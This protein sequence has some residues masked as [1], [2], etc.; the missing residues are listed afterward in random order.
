MATQ[1]VAVNL[2]C[3]E[4]GLLF[5]DAKELSNHK[6][7]FCIGCAYADPENLAAVTKRQLE[8]FRAD[9]NSR[10]PAGGTEA[11]YN[12]ELE[13]DLATE[14]FMLER[15]QAS[16]KMENDLKAQRSELQ[17][18]GAHEEQ[19]RKLLGQLEET[20]A[21][22][23]KAVLRAQQY[24]RNL[25]EMDR[26]HIETLQ[27]QKREELEALVAE[28]E[29][30]ERQE[31]EFQRE[32]EEMEHQA[33]EL[34]RARDAEEERLT[35]LV[36]QNE[37]TL[38]EAQFDRQRQ[39]AMEHGSKMEQL[40]MERTKLTEKKHSITF[41]LDQL[42]DKLPTQSSRKPT[43]AVPTRLQMRLRKRIDD[44]PPAS[45]AR[46]SFVSAFK[47]DTAKVSG[48]APE[49]IDIVGIEEGSVMVTF[50]IK[51]GPG[52]STADA[53]AA[54]RS[55]QDGSSPTPIAGAMVQPGGLLV[56]EHKAAH[57]AQ[58]AETVEQMVA[59]LQAFQAQDSAR[60]EALR[61]GGANAPPKA[62]VSEA[63]V[64]AL[65]DLEGLQSP[66]AIVKQVSEKYN[67][68][69]EDTTVARELGEVLLEQVTG[70]KYKKK[71]FLPRVRSNDTSSTP[72]PKETKSVSLP[73]INIHRE[74]AS[75]AP[76]A[77]HSPVVSVTQPGQD[78]AQPQAN[79]QRMPAPAPVS[80]PLGQPP[81]PPQQPPLPDSQQQQ[82]GYMPQ[83]PGFPAQ[84]GGF[85]PQPQGY[86]PSSF[87]IHNPYMFGAQQQNPY[88]PPTYNPYGGALPGAFSPQYA[89]QMQLQQQMVQ[90]QALMQQHEEENQRIQQLQ[91]GDAGP[92]NSNSTKTAEFSG[93]TGPKTDDERHH[94]EMLA[95]HQ[96]DMERMR[97]DMEKLQTEQQLDKLM[98]EAQK[99]RRERNL[100]RQAEEAEA[101]IREAKLRRQLAK[102]YPSSVL[103]TQQQ[104][105][106]DP[107]VYDPVRG[108]TIFMDFVFGLPSK[109]VQS[110]LVYGVYDGNAPKAPAKMLSLADTESA[111]AA[112]SM[113]IFAAKRSFK[114]INGAK[115]LKLVFEPH[116]STT[117]ASNPNV[118]PATKAIGWTG[119]HLFNE[120][121]DGGDLRLN[122]GQFHLPIFRPPTQ[123]TLSPADMRAKPKVAKTGVF[124][125]VVSNH[126][127]NQE[128]KDGHEKF[129]INPPS[130]NNNYYEMYV[131]GSLDAPPDMQQK[132]APPTTAKPD[133]IGL[134]PEVESA[135]PS[136]V[137]DTQGSLIRGGRAAGIVPLNNSN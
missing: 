96:R 32:L 87:G 74:S 10:R 42:N 119:L 41:Q 72:Q 93:A 101:A 3:R 109:A 19:I 133:S 2:E 84:P 1:D 15:M 115:S 50:D 107:T 113:C 125:R 4:C 98:S 16:R 38:Q 102:E 56:I 128:V 76:E 121:T 30:L 8:R 29:E 59:R 53:V 62:E 58:A 83:P 89:L 131:E 129:G 117:V 37:R 51:E 116:Y 25:Q 94:E 134:E 64:S 24:S 92:N 45:A 21:D 79:D 100:E 48:V 57:V 105:H 5:A 124:I 78:A 39:L 90:A 18:N 20:K 49:R 11:D 54:L 91:R 112:G 14:D 70:A 118:R 73:P 67:A 22:E 9:A 104:R 126:I 61:S 108:F 75:D 69:Q 68:A 26:S 81:Q 95:K 122:A 65:L 111:Q 27:G 55:D 77:Q 97:W 120:S 130:T 66:G 123:P 136:K 85:A 110:S 23:F 28:R 135:L 106:V 35:S 17:A 34:A 52:L 114:N 12:K 80:T 44:I 31:A 47:Q 127:L 13:L 7:R 88:A 132:A 6:E 137:R 46:I 36:K 71:G 60:L 99:V 33:L 43:S 86:G 103:A 63:D 40:K 82:F